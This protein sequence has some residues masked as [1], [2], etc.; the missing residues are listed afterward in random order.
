V[1]AVSELEEDI[2]SLTTGLQSVN[3]GVLENDT[4]P[5][6]GQ[7]NNW[8]YTN[9]IAV[10]F[11][12]RSIAFDLGEMMGIGKIELWNAVST[13]RLTQGNYSIYS[14]ND[15]I[16]YVQ[17][18]NWT[19][20]STIINGQLI[21]AFTFVN[22]NAKYVKVHQNIADTS[23]NY[24]FVLS[25]P[26][27]AAKVYD[28]GALLPQLPA[29]VGLADNDLQPTTGPLSVWGYTDGVAID[30]HSGSVGFDLGVQR[31]AFL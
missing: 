6:A 19:F 5:I 13:T 9:G 23:N 4:N 10:D 20:N 24:T 18:N 16:T 30:Y 3:V 28:Q 8:G 11:N 26:Q 7:V 27:T 31:E 25:N 12:S 17:V 1:S 22:L 2:T 21:H 29:T 14:S 15:N